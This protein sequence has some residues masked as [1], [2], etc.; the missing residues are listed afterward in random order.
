MRKRTYFAAMLAS[1]AVTAKS[2]TQTLN[3][4]ELQAQGVSSL[5]Q[6]KSS[7]A[8]AQVYGQIRMEGM[9][10]FTSIPESPQLSFSQ[11]LSARLS[12]LKETSWVDMVADVSGGTFFSRGQSHFVVHEAYLA[13]HGKTDLK[14]FLGRKK[15]DWSEL[16]SHWQLGLW[17]PKFAIDALR[18]EEQ[19]LSG[20]FVDYNTQGWE[21]LGFATPIFIPSMGPDIREEGGGLVADSRWYRAPSRDFA[22]NNRARK[23]VYELD[24]PETAKLVGNGA[25]AAMGRLGNKEAG[26]WVVASGGYLPVNELILK[27]KIIMDASQVDADVTVSPDVTYHTVFSTDVGYTFANSVKASLSYLQDNPL[28]KHAESEDWAI[29]KLM[30]LQAYSA[31]VDFSLHNIFSKTLAFQIA[32]LKVEGGGIE[33]IRSKGEPDDMTLFDQRLKFTNA[34]SFSVEG[35]LASFF[36]RPFVT[37]FKYLYD[38]DQRGSLL[39]TEFLYYPSQKW[40]VVMGGDILGVQDESYNP[41]SFLNQYRANDRVYGGMTYVF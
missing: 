33:D 14:V 31:S 27:R 18:P 25:V 11:L 36:R 6:P 26:G 8:P 21:I 7:S 41:S 24:I 5:Q 37:R 40:A 16:D 38:Y 12:A 22:L 30:P 17:Q 29:Q 15:K 10:Y 39:N 28:V 2:K 19:G 34:L 20:L 32:Y 1:M 13:S 4:K 3:L 23:I 9:Q 35:Q